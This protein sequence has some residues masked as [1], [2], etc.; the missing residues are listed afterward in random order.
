MIFTSAKRGGYVTR[1]YQNNLKS[2]KQI[3][4]KFSGN[5]DNAIKQLTCKT[6][7]EFT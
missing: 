3:L 2:C 6:A 4:M 7:L 5:V 1:R